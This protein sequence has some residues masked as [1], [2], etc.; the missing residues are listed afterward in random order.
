MKKWFSVLLAALMLLSMTALAEGTVGDVVD[1]APPQASTESLA[2][3]VSYLQARYNME[4]G[5]VLVYDDAEFTYE[6]KFGRDSLTAVEDENAS[7]L[8][9]NTEVQADSIDALL[10]EAVGGYGPDAVI[11]EPTEKLLS[12]E[13]DGHSGMMVKSID[14]QADGTV[15]RFYLV[16]KPTED[17]EARIDVLCIT[18]SFPADKA[19][20]YGTAFD[21]VVE[22][23]MFNFPEAQYVADEWQLW[24]PS[25]LIKP[26]DFY[27]KDS[28]VPIDEAADASM[29]VVLSDVAPEHVPD[30][31]TEAMGGYE[32]IHAASEQEEFVTDNNMIIRWFETEQ[33]GTTIRY[34]ALWSYNTLN[35]DVYC[36][37]ASFPTADES[38]YGAAFDRMV[39]SF[40]LNE[41]A[42]D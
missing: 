26:Q 31:L 17:A 32:G 9:S 40:A 11:G 24:Y 14:A 6:L 38:L 12:E 42:V 33:N 8:I 28:F 35:D 18:A 25:E 15:S 29:I 39:E 27:G 37:T 30:F 22:S 23:M 7:M 4:L 10:N 41:T 19:D 13:K 5:Y 20:A 3:A 21:N 34:Y 36:I 2:V 16:Y 1:N